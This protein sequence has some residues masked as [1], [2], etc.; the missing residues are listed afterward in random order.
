MCP[1]R[2]WVDDRRKFLVFLKKYVFGPV[3]SQYMIKFTRYTTVAWWEGLEAEFPFCTYALTPI[4]QLPRPT[5]TP[6]RFTG[7][8]YDAYRVA[9]FVLGMPLVY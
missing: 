2:V 9:P 7:T 4:N 6:E 3:E 1:P 5:N 8:F